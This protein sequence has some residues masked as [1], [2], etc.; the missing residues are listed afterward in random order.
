MI[1]MALTAIRLDK[2][3]ASTSLLLWRRNDN[4]QTKEKGKTAIFPFYLGVTM[5]LNPNLV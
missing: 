2:S 3:E 5:T 1:S 4:V